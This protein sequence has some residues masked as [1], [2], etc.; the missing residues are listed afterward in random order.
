MLFQRSHIS[1]SPG[2]DSSGSPRN[3]RLPRLSRAP[4]TPNNFN[5]AM[6]QPQ[7]KIFYFP[8]KYLTLYG[9]IG[10]YSVSGSSVLSAI[11]EQ[12]QFPIKSQNINLNK[13][14]YYKRELPKKAQAHMSVNSQKFNRDESHSVVFIAYHSKPKRRKLKDSFF[15]TI[16][17]FE[18][19]R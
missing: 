7:V 6:A 16:L 13:K 18:R 8:V 11:S 5:P 12:F 10:H 17:L 14:A 15:L 1:R 9:I 19:N 4:T 2:G 3:S